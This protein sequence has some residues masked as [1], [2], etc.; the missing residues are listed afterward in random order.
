MDKLSHQNV[1]KHTNTIVFCPQIPSLRD[2]DAGKSKE[3][4]LLLPTGIH[5]SFLPLCGQTGALQPVTIGAT[6]G[7]RP[8]LVSRLFQEL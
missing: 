7:V 1:K 3:L 4:W 2:T 5:S 8:S 6:S